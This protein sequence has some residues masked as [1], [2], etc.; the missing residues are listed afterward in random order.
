MRIL[1][2]IASPRDLAPLDV[3]GE[4]TAH[5]AGARP[6][7]RQRPGAPRLARAGLSAQPPTGPSRWQLPRHPLRRAQRLHRGRQRGHLPRGPRRRQRRSRSTRRCS[8]TCCRTR[9]LLRLVVLNSCEGARTTLTD[10]YAG[11]ATT[12]VQL[13]VP[14]VV[15]MQFEISDR[16]AIVFAEELYTNLIGR[17]D[18]IDA[19]GG[20]GP[21]GDLQRRRQ[22][23]VG[24]AGAV[25]ARPRRRA[26]PLRRGARV[27][28][29]VDAR[30]AAARV[31][32]STGAALAA[33]AGDRR[34]GG[35]RGRADRRSW[36]GW[37][38]RRPTSTSRD[39]HDDTSTS[40]PPVRT[41]LG[42]PQ[43]RVG[44]DGA[45]VVALQRLL[46][47]QG[48]PGAGDRVLRRRHRGSRQGARAGDQ[49]PARRHR[50]PGD[51]AAARA[52]RSAAATAARPC[53][54]PRSCCSSA[55]FD[56]TPDDR[57][58]NGTQDLVVQFQQRQGL[59]V[60]GIVDIDTWRVLLA[61]AF[62]GQNPP[63]AAGPPTTTATTA[64]TSVAPTTSVAPSTTY[65]RPPRARESA[66][67][68]G[69]ATAGRRPW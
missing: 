10:P 17:R 68:R 50:R 26:V 9:T 13:G 31:T 6:G 55:G 41:E 57:F 53:S 33:A 44:D 7:R 49:H 32:A 51:V 4:R 11:V 52:P 35:R 15:A 22:G 34:R 2:I 8:P 18:P 46:G 30:A 3:A 59:P 12:L 20:R 14:A 54:P 38:G 42:F 66:A 43:V 27:D 47:V 24:D 64:A 28:A 60:D 39:D 25:R 63:L 48:P 1:G 58:T 45:V 5:R 16:A 69:T 62:Q 65:A 37:C 21:Q 61:L 56:I 19:V 67:G 23:R 29:A 40:A 36:C